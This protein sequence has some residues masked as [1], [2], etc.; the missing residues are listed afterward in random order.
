[1]L[2][3]L[4]K[5]W[6]IFYKQWTICAF[7]WIGRHY[8]S[9]IHLRASFYIPRMVRSNC[10][11]ET[12][13]ISL[14]KIGPCGGEV[15]TSRHATKGH[16]HC[17][18]VAKKQGVVDADTFWSAM[19][20]CITRKETHTESRTCNLEPNLVLLNTS[21]NVAWIMLSIRKLVQSVYEVFPDQKRLQSPAW[22]LL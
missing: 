3:T 11:K 15:M 20:L 14:N 22:L 7:K 1:M 2:R 9:V 19:R 6:Q 17:M 8:P 10:S 12:F 18:S 5:I 4:L 16:D 13:G 21:S